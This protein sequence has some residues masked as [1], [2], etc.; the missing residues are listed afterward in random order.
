[1][2]ICHPLVLSSD[3]T[4]CSYTGCL[5]VALSIDTPHLQ[6]RQQEEEA[7]R[8]MEQDRERLQAEALGRRQLKESIIWLK[9][10]AR[11]PLDHSILK[12]AF[13][14]SFLHFHKRE[15]C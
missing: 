14:P 6:E 2:T 9:L 15:D 13:S 8:K 5:A 12:Y 1:M 10:L 4:G 3:K 7:E 11:D